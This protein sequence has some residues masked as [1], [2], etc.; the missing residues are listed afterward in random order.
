MGNQTWAVAGLGDRLALLSGWKSSGLVQVSF[1][2]MG[3]GHG[4]GDSP[5]ETEPESLCSPQE[6]A[7]ERGGSLRG[8]DKEFPVWGTGGTHEFSA[9]LLCF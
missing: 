8:T 4:Q 7:R 2:G 1:N 6:G 9:S 3:E 5:L